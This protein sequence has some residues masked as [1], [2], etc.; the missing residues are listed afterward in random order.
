MR[1]AIAVLAV[2]AA[3]VTAAVA[4]EDHISDTYMPKD[5]AEKCFN[6]VH[7]R[8]DDVVSILELLLEKHM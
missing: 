3:L 2:L 7:D 1:G 6:G 4:V 5:E 8:L